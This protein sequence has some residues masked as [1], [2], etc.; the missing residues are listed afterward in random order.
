MNIDTVMF[1][2]FSNEDSRHYL[3]DKLLCQSWLILTIESG[4]S[5]HRVL[6]TPKILIQLF[7]II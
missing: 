4:L 3:L 5:R 6:A 2:C 1:Y 7:I